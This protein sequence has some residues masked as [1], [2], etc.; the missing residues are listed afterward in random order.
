MMTMKRKTE[1]NLVVGVNGTGKTTFLEKEVL[2]KYKK[3]L[4][5]TPDNSEWKTLPVVRADELKFFN[6]IGKMIYTG[7]EILTTIS[8]RFYG[9]A[10]ILDDALAYLNEQTPATMQYIYIRRRQ[11]GIDIYLVAHGLRQIPPKAFSFASWLILF[12]TVENFSSRKKEIIPSLYDSIIESQQRIR[13]RVLNGEP[14]YKEYIL[15][16]SQIKSLYAKG[17]GE[18]NR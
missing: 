2:S 14:Y 3:A 17:K 10:L 13:N 4:V 12:N 18:A 11:F 8:R 6:G 1:L 5:L 16:D 7:P 9:G 15:I